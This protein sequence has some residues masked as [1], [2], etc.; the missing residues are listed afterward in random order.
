MVRVQSSEKN[1]IIGIVV[2]AICILVYLGALVSI[3]IRISTSME[4]QRLTAEH[5]F[6]DLADQANSAG[7]LSFM[8]ETFVEIIQKNLDAS[9]TLEGVIISGPNG[10]YGFEKERGRA[11]NYVNGLPRFRNRIDL[12]GQQLYQSLRIQGLRN[13]NIQGKARTLDY[14]ELTIIL[15]QAMFLVAAALLV[16][17]FVLVIDSLQRKS[18][19]AFSRPKAHSKPDNKSPAPNAGG[20]AAGGSYSERGRIVREENTELR[21]TEELQRCA[22][23]GQDL[24]FIVIEYKSV[25]DETFYPRFTADAAR[26]FSSRDF[27]CE[28]GERGIS[29]IC[30]DFNL[31][32]GFLNADEFHNRVMG[33]YPALLAAKTDLCMGLSSRAGRPVNAERL[34]FEAEEALERAMMDPVSHIVAF[35]SDP[36]KYR[37]FMESRGQE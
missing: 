2:A 27:V 35:K 9:K 20:Y 29:V 10:E 28:R 17:L 15:K 18:A 24:T 3:V 32:A 14:M 11:I 16:A 13:V 31:D 26:F 22:A 37:A 30:P 33:K 4:Q 5:E 7:L 25:T 34:M 6:F 1:S 19:K 36:E 21:L 8:D 23:L 12:S